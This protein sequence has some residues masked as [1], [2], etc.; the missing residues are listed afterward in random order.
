[1]SVEIS[2]EPPPPDLELMNGEAHIF[3]AAL[4]ELGAQPEHFQEIL[5]Q[6]ER[7]RAAR[8]IMTRDRNRFVAAR[9]AMRKILGWLLCADPARLVFAYG[10]HGK[11][12]LAAPV[13]GRF[14][15]F[16]LAHSDALAVCVVSAGDNVGVD[17]E[18]VRTVREAEAIAA[19]FFPAREFAEWRS[20][21]TEQQEGAFFECWTRQE[22]LLKASGSG[23]GGLNQIQV[24]P[25][26]NSPAGAPDLS[27]FSVHQFTPASGYKAAA[28]TKNIR[29]PRCWKW[30]AQ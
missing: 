17:V 24:Q 7:A 20:L 3:C 1:M 22:A 6:D 5:S 13:G 10:E 18:R 21:P 25:E 29:A 14:L 8:F 16:N 12:R 19:Q 27:N 9:A 28:A 4:E 26:L 15:H 11:P 23:L 2:F 30:P